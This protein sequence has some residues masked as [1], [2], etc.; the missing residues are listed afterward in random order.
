VPTS[1]I[2]RLLAIHELGHALGYRHEH[3]H[4]GATPRCTESGTYEELTAF[5]T[6]SVMKYANCTLGSNINGTELSL[7]DGIGAR[8]VY[9]PPNWWW[10]VLIPS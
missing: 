3:I 4:S 7:L 1:G 5:D 10:A 9:G 8:L 6:L 2:D